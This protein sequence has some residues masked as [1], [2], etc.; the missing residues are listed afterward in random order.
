MMAQYT[1]DQFIAKY[2][3]TPEEYAKRNPTKITKVNA[4]G[5][6]SQPLEIPLPPGLNASANTVIDAI[7]SLTG[8]KSPVRAP[9]L[10]D[11][12]ERNLQ[13]G[14][15]QTVSDIPAVLD[16]AR[17]GI[18]AAVKG[19]VAPNDGE[20]RLQSIGTNFMGEAFQKEAVT[21][22]QNVVEIAAKAYIRNTPSATP[23]QLDDFLQRF[24]DSEVFQREIRK[25]LSAGLRIGAEGNVLANKIV[26]LDVAP[27]KQTAADDAAQIAGQALIGLPAATVKSVG[28][29]AKRIVGKKVM[30]NVA[31]KVA[32]RAAELL[33]PITLPLDKANVIANT[34]MG[35]GVNELMRS[36][37]DMPTLSSD[38]IKAVLGDVKR[39]P[40][41]EFFAEHSDK[42]IAGAGITAGILF[43][44]PAVRRAAAQAAA[45]PTTLARIVED[46]TTRGGATV[47]KQADKLQPVLSS[48][49]G[50]ADINSPAKHVVQMFADNPGLVPTVDAAMSS[51]APSRLQE[52]INNAFEYG[53]LP[54]NV[55]V[56]ALA[57]LERAA[58]R[59]SPED[60]KLFNAAIYAKDRLQDEA[61]L[62]R[63]LTQ[64]SAD[65]EQE[66]TRYKALGQRF[67]G[68]ETKTRARLHEKKLAQIDLQTDMPNTRPSLDAIS[69]GKL[70]T[71]I[72][73][74]EQNPRLKEMIDAYAAIGRGLAESRYMTGRASQADFSAMVAQRPLY[75]RRWERSRPDVTDET[76]RK[77]LT[78]IDRALGR[79]AQIARKLEGDVKVNL[80][81]DAIVALKGAMHDDIGWTVRNAARANVIDIMRSAGAENKAF[82]QVPIEY[83]DKQTM[84][85]SVK[86]FQKMRQTG[87]IKNAHYF[88]D[89]ARY[90]SFSRNGKVELYEIGDEALAKS[91]Q[92]APVHAL[93]LF[94]FSRKVAQTFT[95]GLGA[96]WFAAKS[97]IWDVPVAKATNMQGRSFG[98]ID[99]WSR[100]LFNESK[101]VNWI[102]DK[103]FDPTAF[104]SAAGGM[105]Y[106]LYERAVRSVALKIS[107]DLASKNGVFAALASVPKGKALLEHAATVLTRQFDE[108]VFNVMSQQMSITMSHLGDGSKVF[109]DYATRQVKYTGALQSV[110]NGY[111]A[112]VESIQMGTRTAFF[113]ENY[114]RLKVKYNGHVPADVVKALAHETANLTGDMTRVSGNK[115]IQYTTSAV[116]YLN[117]AIQGTRHMLAA[118]IPPSVAGTVNKLGGN[119]ITERSNKFWTQFTTG[120]L[121]PKLGALAVLSQWE[122]AEDWWYNKTPKWKQQSTIPLPN[123]AAL[124][125]FFEHN[126]WPTFSPEYVNEMPIA[127]EMAMIL[128]PAEAFLRASGLIGGG[129]K[130]IEQGMMREIADGMKQLTSF[131]TNPLLQ[132]PFALEHRKFDPSNLLVGEP[133][134]QDVQTLPL[135]G[136]NADH[137][138]YSSD[139]PEA[140][141]LFITGALVSSGDLFMQTFNVFDIA[142]EEI[143]TVE[144][145]REAADTAN[146]EVARRMP[147][148]D[149]PGLFNAR[150]RAYAS[151]PESEYV[152]TTERDLEPIIGSGRQMS[153]ENDNEGINELQAQLG[154]LP[155]Q[156]LKDPMLAELS[157]AVYAALR[158]D[159]KYK[160]ADKMYSEVRKLIV[161]LD[162][163]RHRMDDDEYNR[164]RNALV[165]QQQTLTRVQ[166]N[167]LK[168]LET[169]MLRRYGRSFVQQFGKPLTMKS[170]ADAVRGAT[171]NVGP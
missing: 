122:G 125:Y 38:A 97:A 111:K 58:Q 23:E 47:E 157:G 57:N 151:T 129:K 131:M 100:R 46:I 40:Q 165:E 48:I 72:L 35:I 45:D 136:A 13:S 120:V 155:A 4:A 126:Q 119:M 171:S 92:F 2:G 30:D 84:A 52:T 169:L 39:P 41:D 77:W 3:M 67:K 130:A 15:L 106:Q 128:S 88:D 116:P 25:G 9:A 127:P 56:P 124:E 18:P 110:F 133:M 137:M 113:Y 152:F 33:T 94:N 34:G 29:T 12:V 102:G 112:I 90:V 145:I 160:Q 80:P 161:A 170:L 1:R 19:V 76:T 55:K 101:I 60:Y 11:R 36:A 73:A 141:H 166:A 50:T 168:A 5:K 10:Y 149:V 24:Q 163:S 117:P 20:G 22:V 31:S 146:F 153:V 115:Y 16:A 65:L 108:S 135:G 98:L 148:I 14:A 156:K 51:A 68:M 28:N 82:R 99:T 93:P 105:G 89:H 32:L 86:Q 83:G 95:T 61:I 74:A 154:L 85:M 53:T 81:Q 107:D 66:A 162:N 114:G 132:V 26:G 147:K 134:V 6:S 62:L 109:D 78:F 121:M 79:P 96:P 87:Q 150:E 167:E 43:S 8:W 49:T 7:E 104:I 164:R 75:F 140:L 71:V 27:H 59:L 91:L 143:G 69:R 159:G 158:R 42:L 44:L 142:Q 103:V 21:R 144:A 138:T 118:T 70:D 63:K 139:I 64:E 123:G 17:I 54:G 37:Q